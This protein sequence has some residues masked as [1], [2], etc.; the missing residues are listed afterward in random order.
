[1]GSRNRSLAAVRSVNEA[2]YRTD[3]LTLA[4]A[5]HTDRHSARFGGLLALSVV[6]PISSASVPDSAIAPLER[7]PLGLVFLLG[8]LMAFGPLSIDTYLPAFPA[9]GADFGASAA[10]VQR[11]LSLYFAGLAVGQVVYG[12][13]A[14]RFGR[15][16]PLLG[17]MALYVAAAIGCALAPSL[18]S[19]T[20]WRFA[21]ALGGCSGM[22]ITRAVVRDLFAP[23]DMA[24]IFSQLMLVM[25]VAPILAPLLGS[26]L[27]SMFG[28]RC[29]FWALAALGLLC[30]L[31]Q[32]LALPESLPAERRA[33]AGV[34]AIVATYLGLL[35]DPRFLAPVIGG[36]LLW[37]TM[38]LYIGGAPFLYM[39]LHGVAPSAFGVFFGINA[40]GMIGVAQVNARLLNKRSP[41]RLL[42]IGGAIVFLSG[43]VLLLALATGRGGLPAV[44]VP[45][46][47][48]L[49][50][51]GFVGGNASSAAL[52]PFPHAAGSASALMGTVQFGI[53]ATA[54]AIAAA[55]FNG[56]A[57]PLAFMITLVA[58]GGWYVVTRWHVGG[59]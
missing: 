57:I 5:G 52:A 49:A 29:I 30:L 28:W 54:G 14:D 55:L 33:K 7:A 6:T 25:G 51:L 53:G 26:T 45:I 38:F 2:S 19:L 15:R 36:G 37:S 48:M 9:I 39:E 13:L 21:Q 31:A 34:R 22:V 56:S 8:T 11:T 10:D 18:G 17:G 47:F 44:A 3:A 27:L 42:R 58:A 16:A 35:R 24:R 40:A 20:A 41:G 59:R 46:F 32:S 23:R 43:V 1:M 12:P 4:P 50:A